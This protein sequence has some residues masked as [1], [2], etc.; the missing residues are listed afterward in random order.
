MNNMPKTHLIVG[1][2]KHSIAH[3]LHIKAGDKVVSV[4]GEAINDIFDYRFLIADEFVTLEIEKSGGKK[5]IYDIEKNYEDDLGLEFGTSLMDE[6]HSCSN[7]CIFCFIDQMPPGMR[8]T[9]YFKDDD[10]RLSFLQGNYITLT[11]MNDSDIDRIIRYRMEPI[12]ISVHTTDPDLRVSMLHNRR[13]GE[14]LGYIKRLADAEIVMNAQIV[15]CKGINDGEKLE[16]TLADLMEYAP[17]LQSVSVVPAGLTKFREKLYPLKPVDRQ[18]ALQTIEIIERFQKRAMKKHG[19]HFCHASDELYLLAGLEMPEEE[20]YD[21]YMQLENG[22]GM[23]RLLEEEYTS[24]LNESEDP[25]CISERHISL[26]CGHSAYAYIRKF[27][28]MFVQRYGGRIDVYE[29]RND[30]FGETITVSGLICGCDLIAQLKGKD[31]GDELLIPVNMLRAGEEYFLDDITISQLESET[32]T[33]I[34]VVPGSG[35]GLFRALAG[36]EIKDYRRQIYEQ[37]DSGDSRQA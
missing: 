11:N 33:K 6:Y 8:E 22:V 1:V 30:F 27:A 5:E 12:N 17:V 16:R 25:G 24:V 10:S 28:D 3:K 7:R 13:A 23:L 35:E 32:G 26:A 36:L 21:G 15:M 20:R 19:I 37:T 18:S 14:V 31:L 29:I 34:T 4:N 9:L 2:E